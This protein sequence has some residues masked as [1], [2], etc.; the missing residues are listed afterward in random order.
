[1]SENNFK[2]NSID[3]ARASYLLLDKAAA[4][5]DSLGFTLDPQLSQDNTMVFIDKRTNQPTIVHRG[6]V[7]PR[8]WLVDDLLIS[9]GSNHET[10][11]LRRARQI[12][13]AA[14]AK[15]RTK[16]N[17]V[18]HSLGGRLAEL[19]G[20]GG[21]IVTFN[22][23]SGLGDVGL[24]RNQPHNRN[25]NGSRQTDVRTKLDLVSAL[26]NLGL[27]R[28]P[29]SQPPVVEVRQRDQANRFLPGPVRF[30][31]NVAKAHGLRNLK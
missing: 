5:G 7:T 8:D 26:S 9:A 1:M 20:S 30:L 17:A 19:A 27:G 25:R 23:A 24:G 21:Q 28:R 31:A 18:G 3:L 12:T 15:Y 4:F 13:A 14:E 22:R 10:Q 2:C 16:S 6:S 29:A 11:R